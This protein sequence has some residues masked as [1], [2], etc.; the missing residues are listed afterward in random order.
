MT[1]V[2]AIKDDENERS[3]AS[4][5]R[6]TFK[7]IVSALAAGDYLLGTKTSN[8]SEISQET[9]RQIQEYIKDYG[10]T[11]IPLPDDAWT[12]SVSIWMGSHWDVFV[13]LW[14]EESGPSDMVLQANKA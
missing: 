6:S 11:L 7:E 14:T 13:D 1:D 5:W 10:E 4:D 3:V 8:V 2:E 9:A 12:T